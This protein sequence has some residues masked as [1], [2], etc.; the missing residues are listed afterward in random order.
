[1]AVPAVA[2]S[3]TCGAPICFDRDAV[4]VGED[5][6]LSTTASLTPAD[7]DRSFLVRV[8][9]FPVGSDTA[10]ADDVG[11][12][13]DQ[14]IVVADTESSVSITVPITNDSFAEPDDR[15]VVSLWSGDGSIRHDSID[16][17]IVDDDP[18][19]SIVGFL[20]EEFDRVLALTVPETNDNGAARV[21][22]IPVGRF[23]ANESGGTIDAHV[24]I[25]ASSTAAA[26][27][28]FVIVGDDTFNFGYAET[29]TFDLRLLDDAVIEGDETI[30]LDLYA[31]PN[32]RSDSPVAIAP[33]LDGIERRPVE[34]FVITI[35]D[36]DAPPPP[37]P[38]IPPV[39]VTTS[40]AVVEGTDATPGAQT[41]HSLQIT[42]DNPNPD[43]QPMTWSVP[44]VL[45]ESV[46]PVGSASTA[47]LQLVTAVSFLPPGVSVA[48][49]LVLTT[50]D[51]VVEPSETFL[52]VPSPGAPPIT[53][54]IVNDDIGAPP[55]PPPPV[56]LT[57]EPEQSRF[58]EGGEGGGITVTRSPATDA[59]ELE[60]T[61]V[62]RTTTPDD[63]DVT[64]STLVF[65]PGQASA[66][67]S[68][69]VDNDDLDEADEETFDL[70]FLGGEFVVTVVVEDND[71]PPP[72]SE[73]AGVLAQGIEDWFEGVS[74]RSAEPRFDVAMESG[75]DLGDVD[76]AGLG[77]PPIDPP[78]IPTDLG[79]LFDLGDLLA[80]VPAPIVD[81]ASS[82]L[83]DVVRDFE[84][85][86]C[87]ADFAAGG[88][89][90]APP[91]TGEFD[92]I[93]V[94][95]TRALDELLEASGYSGDDLNGATPDV[96]RGLASA[97]G[98]DADIDWRADGLVELVAGVDGDGFYVL[99]SSGAQL[100][101][102]GAGT[103]VGSGT[104]AG[105]Q[106]TS[107]DGNAD[108][109][110][111]VGVRMA[112][113]RD[114]RLRT[115][116]LETIT[117]RQLVRTLDGDAAMS[118]TATVDETTLAWDATWTSAPDATGATRITTTQ[119][120]DLRIDLPGFAVADTEAPTAIELNGVLAER[121]GV[122]GW[123][124]TGTAVPASGLEL[125][126]FTVTRLAASGFVSASVYD[127][128]IDVGL[129]IG[130]GPGA[131]TVNGQL[132]LGN[133]GWNLD[134][135]ASIDEVAFGPI[136]LTD[137][138]F[139][140][141]GSY[142]DPS[143]LTALRRTEGGGSASVSVS[144]QAATAEVLDGDGVAVISLQGLTGDI[145]S[146]GVVSVVAQQ[147]AADIGNVLRIELTDV[148]VG[149][150]DANGVVLAVGSARATA[151]ELGDLAV[152]ITDLELLADG[153]FTARSASIDQPDGIAQTIGLAGLVP[154]DVTSLSLAFTNVDDD[155]RVVDLSQFEVA[156][157]GTVDLSG[158]AD[159]PFEPVLQLGGDVITPASSVAE[160]AISFSASVSSVDPLVVTPLDLGPI[161]LG[162]RD[163]TV[164][165]VVV[166]AEITAAGFADGALLPELGGSA[167]I[168]GGFG[169]LT[170]SLAADLEGRFVDGPTGVEIEATAVI[171]FSAAVR[172]GASI[173]DLAVTL[174]LRLGVD[175]G[176]PFLDAAL[177]DVSVASIEVPFGDIATIRLVDASFDFSATG[178]EIAFLIDGDLADEGTGASLL[179]DTGI[180]ALDGWG[181]RIGNVGISADFGL[182]F[183][184]G[185]FVDV[186]VPDGEQFGLPEFIPLRVDEIGLELPE[187]IGPGDALDDVLR[188]LRFSFSGGLDGTEEFPITA[189]VDD[190]VVDI[191]RLL[192]FDPTAPLDLDTFP[193]S[194]LAGVSF[195]ID[196][197][198]DLGAARVS[199]G[200]TF[201]TTTVATPDGNEEVLYARIGGLLSTPAF[202]AGADVVV[203]Q[204]GPVLLKVTAPL[205][206][207]LGPTGFLLT[208]V[209]GAAAF[210]DVRIDPPRDGVP[211]D[212]LTELADLPT[213]VDV[214]AASIAA[215]VATS[216]ARGVPTWESGFALA[217]EGQLTHVTAAGLVSGGV[218]LLSSLTPGRGAQLIGRG[219]I[220]VFGIPLGGGVS[221]SGSVA[222]A[223]FLIDLADPI[224]P[225]FD[226]AF[227]SPTPGSP[228]AAVFP[229]RTT[230]AGQLRTDGVVDGVAAGL[231]AFLDGFSNDGL[232]RIADRLERDRA[233]PLAVIALDAD[234]DGTA[235][236]IERGQTITAGLLRVRLTSLLDDPSG[237]ARAAA[238]LI[239]AVSTE[240]GSLSASEAQALGAEFLA[241][242]AQAGSDAL[243]AAD[244]AFDPSVTLRGAL[245]PLI[246]GFPL[247]DP[248]TSFEVLI[249]RD[250]L[251][252]AVSTSIIEQLK[253]QFGFLS[254]TGALGESLI[255][256]ATLGAR[257]D[258][259]VGVQLPLPGLGDVLL[260]GGTFPSLSM[261]DPNWSVTLAGAFSQFGMRAEVTGFITSAGNDAF[262]DARIERRYLSDGT[263]PPDPSRTQFTRQQDYDNLI[264]YGGLVLDGRL[265]VPRLLTDPVGVVEDLPP[266][267][268]DLAGSIAWFDEFGATVGQTETPVRL[269]A[270]VPGL[271]PLIDEEITPEA[272]TSAVSVTGVFEGTRRNPGEPAVARLLSLPIGEGRLLATTAGLEVTANVPLIGA[273]GRFVLRV[274]DRSGVPVPA[275][276][277]EV[278][279][280]TARLQATLRDLGVPDV[281][282]VPGL[283]ASAGFRAFTP[284]FDPSSP[285][286]LRR[287][288]GVALRT[289]VDAPGF[290]SDAL[291]D[292]SV[293][294]LGTGSGPDF[295]AAASVARVGPFG[296]VEVT[297]A[298][299]VVEKLGA[300]VS[301][302]LRGRAAV[303]GSTWNVE[304][305]LNPDLTGQLLLLG[306]DGE[307]PDFAGFRFVEGGLALTLARSGNGQL[308]G[309]VGIAGRVQLPSWLAGRSTASTVAAAGC[310]GTSGAAEFRLGIGRI[311]L[312][313]TGTAALVGTGAPLPVDPN[314]VC[315]LPPGAGGL[316]NNDARL[317]VRVRNGSTTV[318]VDGAVT[319]ANSGLPLLTASG[320][321]S[322]TGTGELDVRFDSSGLDLS[323]FQLR[324]GAALR[325]L[326]ANQFDLAVDGQLSVPGLVTNAAVSGAITSQGIQRLAVSTS[327]LSLAP[328]TVT[329]S[330]LELVRVGSAYRLDADLRV[331]ID[332]LRRAGT[333]ATTV[334]VDGSIQPNGNFSLAVAG[335]GFVVVGAPV[336]GSVVF[337]RTGAT[338][339]VAVDGRFGLWGSTLDADGS[340]TVG[341]NGLAGTLTLS[342][343]GGIRF[344]NFSLGGTLRLQFSAGSTNTASISLQNG[345]V[346]IPGLGTFNA[347]AA[348]STSGSGSINVSTPSGIR[349]GGASS[350]LVAVGSFRLAFDGLAVTFSASNV[351]LEYRSGATLV[352]RA[353][354]PSFSVSSTELFPIV[355]DIS[356][357]GLDV[358]TFFRAS[359]ASFRLTVEPTS[360]RFELREISN[361]DPQVSVFGGTANMRLRS[362]LIT[363]GGTFQGRIDGSLSLFGKPIAS[364]DYDISLNT[365]RLRLTIPTAQAAT[366]DL[367]F[368]RVR[369]SGFVQSD[370]QFDMTGTATTRGA[371]PGVSWSGSAT[372][373]VRNAGISGSYDGTVS[374]VGLSAESSGTI[375]ETGQVRGTVRSDLNF[376][377]S[378]AGFSVC[379]VVCAFVSESAPFSFNL[380]GDD[381]GAPPDTTRP[382]MSA[383]ANMTVTTSQSFGSITVHYNPPT[384]TDNRDGTL[385]PRCTPGSGTSFPVG[386]TTTVTCTAT[387]AAGNSRTV[388]FTITVRVQLPIVTVVSSS[389]VTNLGGFRPLSKTLLTVFSDP[390]VLAEVVT[391]ATGAAEYRFDVPA[392]LPPGPH[393]VTVI[394]VAPDGSDLLWVVP[395]VVAADGSLSEVRVGE[396]NAVP[397]VVVPPIPTGAPAVPDVAPTPEFRPSSGPLPETGT[398]PA[399]TLT[400]AGGVAALGLLLRLA[401]RRRRA[402]AG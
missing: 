344:G 94:R 274:D 29:A 187:S 367:G 54:T 10:V 64:P 317:V 220:E 123:N 50:A 402:H 221:V 208:S 329:S 151:T 223:G 292:V 49:V 134:A 67:L 172:N 356:L 45:D 97:L 399:S 217:L 273:D 238:P 148:A 124:I 197:A 390:R 288:G 222:T 22:S 385:F 108:A 213:D 17:L 53:V 156:V 207:P 24:A 342:S 92:V 304:G 283:D 194:N 253:S 315:S 375:D 302:D 55:P 140:V 111:T 38:L 301:I 378:T 182:V 177:V 400:L 354:V 350:P 352:F 199:G 133:G 280:T 326:G 332:G 265:E 287:R 81:A 214:D 44:L 233:N 272:W 15:F 267:P 383:P 231:D 178:D 109:D 209:T 345:T 235:S 76:W 161:T 84:A 18:P 139:E 296:G 333:T 41:F 181:G 66:T 12:A 183:Q 318:A 23:S 175:D 239:S 155:G 264:R 167:S 8:E 112:A 120:L 101:V 384:A 398:T 145:R 1:M 339:A 136:R 328:V 247:G 370:G 196:P 245:Q 336:D 353:V 58:R 351:G 200:L 65:E 212:L 52:L 346:T 202:D 364:G 305:R 95:C 232:A 313:P 77:L 248:D 325:L 90:G 60:V 349:I 106:N 72:P 281:F 365:G 205:G 366:I 188:Q 166:D 142:Q 69:S 114:E 392:D 228:L 388:T 387:D 297:D 290:V 327:G 160:R 105:G 143:A 271:G 240:L 254:G 119:E 39:I 78:V 320:S 394:G 374:V 307:L 312:D 358:G 340:L 56:E 211:E 146:S 279:L 338:L 19:Q 129:L 259:T 252:F 251:G 260:S 158:F 276:G 243:G 171:G 237:A 335:T 154:V 234:G 299:I 2:Q 122:V 47:D 128:T 164:G 249:D 219:D 382:T 104:V 269:T 73:I 226:F 334:D 206:I 376:D 6:G 368:F 230:L 99:G 125:D 242:V 377:G 51:D 48:S 236:A 186:S 3:V 16:V 176:A 169:D 102:Q 113:D 192:A 75:F 396:A 131:V 135:T 117:P 100:R 391:D 270:F 141:S 27:D 386:Q 347:T 153:R 116:D 277:L 62:D 7:G 173:E 180:E 130:D 229:A 369:V 71:D 372:M 127:V 373:R 61:V 68:V 126:G 159:L 63:Y 30:V 330:T 57:F 74:G 360:A 31:T 256:A 303:A 255:T 291:L 33:T 5:L 147:A 381:S 218:T 83:A 355:R 393:T 337:S 149:T 203:S 35:T 250:S 309:S 363:S 282:T 324:G 21:V 43:P 241:V 343:P 293:D 300:A 244:A 204:Y 26:V 91:S 198:V 216:V 157:D 262:V 11:G 162:L 189:T 36:D 34:R 170:G 266:I 348:L 263:T 174:D 278:S 191:G 88:A 79:A 389:V 80:L 82:A 224:A 314:A 98:L 190:L 257:D 359:G 295:R 362:L 96:L 379:V 227:E 331:R 258:L 152:T 118:L 284:G 86:G 25:D 184:D 138:T 42:V 306:S 195:Q 93:Q 341:S 40:V 46:A 285:D 168:T 103:V 32:F 319:I 316:G 85:V 261:D 321:L 380:S 37:P 311:A 401:S 395:I 275:G 397:A 28:D 215:A 323:G 89:G 20:P 357:P 179:F 185:F 289:L 294:P 371:F 59:L 163:L 13:V 9:L 298:A 70:S 322:T 165:D 121:D 150:P 14:L 4:V 110:V 132:D 310:I 201:G 144:L 87:P 137:V 107:V 286:P 268:E 210:G 308:T 246:L 115:D 193:I 361:N 225:R